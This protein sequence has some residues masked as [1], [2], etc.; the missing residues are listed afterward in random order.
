VPQAI[1]EAGFLTHAG[2]RDTLIYNP[3]APARG[4]ANGILAFLGEE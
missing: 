2:D 1:V 4:I 3:E